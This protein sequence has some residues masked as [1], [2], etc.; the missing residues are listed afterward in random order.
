MRRFRRLTAAFVAALCSTIA[1]ATAEERI[2]DFNVSVAVET[3]GDILV[4][5]EIAVIA[6]GAQIRRGVFRDLP[7]FYLKGARKLP[8]LY[9]VKSVARDGAKEPY[10][11][12]KD[13]NAY[14]I[15]IGDADVFLSQGAHRYTLVY[16]VKNQVRYFGAYDEVYWN[17]TGNYWAF[18]IDRARATVTLP[19]GAPARQHAAYT[20]YEGAAERDYD[21]KFAGGAHV[22]ETRSRLDAGEGLTIAV[23]FEKGLIDPPSAADERADWWAEN[24]SATVLGGAFLLLGSFLYSIYARVGRDPPKGPVFARYEPPADHSPAAVHYVFHRGLSG[25]D[26]LIAS[27]VNLAVKKRI[28]IDVDRKKKRTTLKAIE[29]AATP[30]LADVER[31]LESRLL[32][33]GRSLTFG[34]DYNP[35][36]TRAYEVFRAS[37]A[38]RYG[39]AYFRWNIGY[40][41]VAAMFGIGAV[42]LAGNLALAW[43]SLHTLV[44][45]GLVLMIGAGAYFLPAPTQKGQAVRTEI[46]GFRL[47]LKT[48]EEM[49]LN[50]VEV[51]GDAPPPMT[52][53]RYERFLPYAVALGV[54]KPWTEHFEALMPKEAADYRPNWAHGSFGG[55]RSLA[56]LSSALVSN[57]STGVSNSMP[58]SSGSSGSGGGGSSGGGGGGGG[59]GGW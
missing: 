40:L 36:L 9:D 17:A 15:R 41:V 12:E 47:Y 33:S 49:H 54:E 8:Y 42:I 35:T 10:A 23:G 44:V 58:K 38:K 43:T 18:A 51:G 29:G 37:L 56:G 7:R 55:G 26:A 45:I 53:E 3:D 34:E 13:G 46:E 4:T 5:E 31:A 6:E 39:A 48:A 19:G 57:L 25:H 1:P 11:V 22:F 24:A 20:G 14:R 30:P 59:G 27:L 2:T 52:I 16:E 50:A 21:Y 32:A 28:A